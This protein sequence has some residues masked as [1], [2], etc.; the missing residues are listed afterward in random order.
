MVYGSNGS[1]TLAFYLFIYLKFSKHVSNSE[2]KI[3]GLKIN[4]YA[5]WHCRALNLVKKPLI[6]CHRVKT[7]N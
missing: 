3:V 2:H 5:A 7:G 1:F 6:T 4:K